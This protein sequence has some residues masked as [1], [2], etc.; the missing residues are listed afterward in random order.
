ML[1]QDAYDT[2]GR[3]GFVG[4]FYTGM[5]FAGVIKRWRDRRQEKRRRAARRKEDRRLEER[6][7]K[8]REEDRRR[9]RQKN[10]IV[11]PPHDETDE[12]GKRSQRNYIVD[13]ITD[14]SE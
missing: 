12:V 13:P 11:E 8:W 7:R 6:R 5:Y 14:E 3:W 1:R 9:D 4:A 2:T 10:Y